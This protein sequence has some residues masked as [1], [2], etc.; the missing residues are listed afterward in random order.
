MFFHSDYILQLALNSKKGDKDLFESHNG[1]LERILENVVSYGRNW[2]DK[3]NRI[4][5]MYERYHLLKLKDQTKTSVRSTESKT[6]NIRSEDEVDEFVSA[7]SNGYV[8]TWTET[9]CN[10]SQAER[11]SRETKPN[12]TQYETSNDIFHCDD[13]AGDIEN[14]LRFFLSS[15]LSKIRSVDK[16]TLTNDILG[17]TR[18]H[19]KRLCHAFVRSNKTSKFVVNEEGLIAS[20]QFRHHVQTNKQTKKNNISSCQDIM[21]ETLSRIDYFENS[22]RRLLSI[23]GLRKNYASLN[24][25]IIQKF[26]IQII[27]HQLILKMVDAMS[28]PGFIQYYIVKIYYV[29][30]LP[31]DTKY[32]AIHKHTSPNQP[33]S[34]NS[35]FKET[36]KQIKA[37]EASDVDD[38]KI[39]TDGY[40]KLNNVECPEVIGLTG[41][42]I[43]ASL[44]RN[45]MDD[46]TA[47]AHYPERSSLS[48]G[49]GKITQALGK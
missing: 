5:E 19:L 12:P 23:F 30:S 38:I 32:I 13:L 15:I 46:E 25:V 36:E 44:R 6:S 47:K 41:Y 33:R 26:L 29:L 35:T 31:I 42:K 40:E 45:E 7:I 17:V 49:S 10:T 22:A 43:G 1:I 24:S 28:D 14:E 37:C 39:S 8:R 27:A 2:L 21:N 48:R 20:F 16:M 18:C 9:I 4:R 11:H 3:N 34:N